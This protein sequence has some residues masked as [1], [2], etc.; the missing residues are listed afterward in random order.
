MSQLWSTTVKP[1]IKIKVVIEDLSTGLQLTPW[2]VG[3]DANFFFSEYHPIYS[4]LHEVRKVWNRTH[5]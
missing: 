1:F 3:D 4:R 2:L 5:L